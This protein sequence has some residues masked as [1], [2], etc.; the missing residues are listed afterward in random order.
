[1]NVFSQNEY[2]EEIEGIANTLNAINRDV[3]GVLL[4]YC[5]EFSC[6]V[7]DFQLGDVQIRSKQ[8]Y[9]QVAFPVS[10]YV[11]KK[12]EGV[13][14]YLSSR[15]QKTLFTAFNACMSTFMDKLNVEEQTVSGWGCH[16]VFSKQAPKMVS[17]SV[18]YVLTL[19][20]A[21]NFN[22]YRNIPVFMRIFSYALGFAFVRSHI[23]NGEL[24]LEFSAG[25]PIKDV[26]ACFKHEVGADYGTK[27]NLFGLSDVKIE[28][29][30]VRFIAVAPKK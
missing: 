23:H 28:K 20:F 5:P 7:Q 30:R 26:E 13:Q 10:L 19:V 9:V 2:V 15:E 11:T 16:V 14:P 21:K 25:V 3:C 4:E 17:G 8:Q 22:Y 6:S 12:Q 29:N 24:C 18:V 1:M 27:Y